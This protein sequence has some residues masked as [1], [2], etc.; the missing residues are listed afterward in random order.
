[1]LARGTNTQPPFYNGS[2][3]QSEEIPTERFRF[4]G[5]SYAPKTAI[6]LFGGQGI[7]QDDIT[8]D[9]RGGFPIQKTAVM[10]I[11]KEY[12]N[13]PKLS[14]YAIRAFVVSC[15]RR[16]LPIKS[17]YYGIAGSWRHAFKCVIETDFF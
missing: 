11:P 3:V 1:M 4:A 5:V 13:D 7:W 6:Y 14:K 15:T 8:G 16:L 17:S 2:W 10:Y 9:G 12:R